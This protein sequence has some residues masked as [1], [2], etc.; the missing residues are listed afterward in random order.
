MVWLAICSQGVESLVRFEKG[1]LDHHR[2]IKEVLPVA[3]RYGNCKFGN[4]WTF[5]QGNGTSHTHQETQD[6][7]SQL[8][9]HRVREETVNPGLGVPGFDFPG[10]GIPGTGNS[11]NSYTYYGWPDFRQ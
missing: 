6:W 4:N 9:M 3:L 7:R 11:G 2:Y 1:T 5:Q 10:F 8:G